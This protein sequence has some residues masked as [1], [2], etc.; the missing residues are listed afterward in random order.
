MAE[1][2]ETSSY[3]D[4]TFTSYK[5]YKAVSSGKLTS[6][7]K[8]HLKGETDVELCTEEFKAKEH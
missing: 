5:F 7:P 8:M 2:A 3:T 6:K 4:Y 1:R